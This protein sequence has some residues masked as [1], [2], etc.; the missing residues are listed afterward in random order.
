MC[1]IVENLSEHIA[2]RVFWDISEDSLLRATEETTYFVDCANVIAMLDG[3]KIKGRQP[4]ETQLQNRDCDGWTKE[5]HRN[6]LLL[7][8]AFGKIV[9]AGVNAPGNYHDSR[10]ATWCGIYHQITTPILI[11][12]Q[13]LR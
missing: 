11:V 10:T 4:Q 5:V 13:L 6:Y 2:S 3:D 7:W 8:Y 1:A 12:N 9:D